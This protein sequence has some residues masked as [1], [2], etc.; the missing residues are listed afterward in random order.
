MRQAGLCSPQ[1]EEPCAPGRLEVGWGVCVH[2]DNRL[3][4]RLQENS[5]QSQPANMLGQVDLTQDAAGQE[6]Q[7][8]DL[9][10]LLTPQSGALGSGRTA[11]HLGQVLEA[12]SCLHSLHPT[13]GGHCL[14][15]I[16]PSASHHFWPWFGNSLLGAG[17]LFG[18][19]TGQ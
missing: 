7:R 8:S 12:L 1:P 3:R 6:E 14:G 19:L 15:K 4:H 5:F 17:S 11:S 13:D 9:C 18:D 16:S 2:R 10:L